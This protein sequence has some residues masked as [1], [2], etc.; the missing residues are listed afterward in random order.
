MFQIGLLGIHVVLTLYT[1]YETIQRY[2]K[3]E[4]QQQQ[5]FWDGFQWVRRQQQNVSQQ[6]ESFDLTMNQTRKD[7]RLHIGI[8]VLS[9]MCKKLSLA[10]VAMP[11]ALTVLNL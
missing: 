9:I 1:Q 7:R 6:Q 4:G 8:L 10:E 2:C 3:C 11:V 5:V